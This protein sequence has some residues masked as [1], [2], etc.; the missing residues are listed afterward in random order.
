MSSRQYRCLAPALTLCT[1]LAMGGTACAAKTITPDAPP[2]AAE[3]AAARRALPGDFKD[4]ERIEHHTPTFSVGLVDLNGDGKADLII[5]FDD[6]LECGMQDCS[7]Y[8][9]L[10]VPGGYCTHAITLALSPPSATMTVL[11]SIHHGMHDLRY[12]HSTYVFRW[13]GTA[14]QGLAR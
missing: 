14:Y 6:P 13:T 1:M 3:I 9:L 11:D 4:A 7:A 8:A 12:D 5:H 10:A 2:T